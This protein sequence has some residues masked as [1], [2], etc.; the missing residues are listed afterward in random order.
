MSEIVA[1]IFGTAPVML[2][3]ALG[4]ESLVAVRV[5]LPTP[6][7]RGRVHLSAPDGHRQLLD[8]ACLD[9]AQPMPLAFDVVM[10]GC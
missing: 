7:T 3:H 4:G 1:L 9:V 2:T 10:H 6:W 5:D 8:E